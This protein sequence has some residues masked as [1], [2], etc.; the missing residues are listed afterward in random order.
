[1][2]RKKIFLDRNENNYGPAPACYD[3][4]RKADLSRLSWYD[5]SFNRGIKGLLSD[6][7]ARARKTLEQVEAPEYLKKLVGTLG[8]EPIDHYPG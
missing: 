8:A 7:L 1:M 6:R 2:T 3:I 4:L 5:R